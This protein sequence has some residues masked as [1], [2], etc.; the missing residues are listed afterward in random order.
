MIEASALDVAIQAIDAQRIALPFEILSIHGLSS[1]K[2]KT[3]LNW[4]CSQPDTNYLEVGVYLGSTFIPAIYGN[5]AQATAIDNWCQFKGKRPQFE[6]N[7]RLVMPERQVQIIDADCFGVDPRLM[8]H[9]VNVFFYD[10]DH[11]REAQHRAFVHFDPVFAPRFVAVVDD[12]NWQAVRD[13]TRAAFAELG[14]KIVKEW[15]LF[16]TPPDNQSGDRAEWWNG[17][18]VACLQ[19]QHNSPVTSRQAIVERNP[20]RRFTTQSS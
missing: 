6:E 1:A 3:L 19:K 16:T 2:V 18:Y 7:L 11:S 17:L 10:G 4:L 15:E 9:G 12:W 8:E 14:Y 5:H 20:C 13:G